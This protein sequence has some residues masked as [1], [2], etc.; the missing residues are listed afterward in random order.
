METYNADNKELRVKTLSG[1]KV[2]NIDRLRIMVQKY[3]SLTMKKSKF[4]VE[5]IDLKPIY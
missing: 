4:L 3:L 2:L 1:T 5:D